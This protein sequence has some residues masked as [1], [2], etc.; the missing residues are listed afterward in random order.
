MYK[1]FINNK[2]VYL[3]SEDNFHKISEKEY[4]Y[5]FKNSSELF[6]IIINFADN[7]KKRSLYIIDKDEKKILKK[8]FKIFHLIKAAGGFV[9]NN[10]NEYLF[11]FRRGVWDL[12][13]GKIDK[14]E[15]KKEAAIRE[16]REECGV[17][18]LEIKNKIGKSYHIFLDDNCKGNL[19]INSKDKQGRWCIK[20]TYWYEMYCGD[21]DN[22]KPQ[23]SED[24]TKIRW[25]DK[26]DFNIVLQNIHNNLIDIL[27]YD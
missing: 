23:T 20:K 9:K 4:K 11:I 26:K 27:N 17:K 22:I 15:T 25:F 10:K 6:K 21:P 7:A 16:V 3:T 14:G 2:V 19:K 12:P 8:L 24:I 18:K 13:K 1:V 5:F